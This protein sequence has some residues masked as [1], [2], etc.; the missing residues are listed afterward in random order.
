MP[1]VTPLGP[2]DPR[3][4]GRY[5]LS[6]RIA[7]DQADPGPASSYVTRL[8]DGAMAAIAMLGTDWA[9]GGASRDR[10]TA[11]ART[12]RRVPPFCAAR[13]LDAGFEGDEPYLVSELVEGPSLTR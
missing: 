11:E 3:R 12:A 1:F 2:E 5:R 7:D 4:V 10:F 9:P 8:P 6:G 13:I